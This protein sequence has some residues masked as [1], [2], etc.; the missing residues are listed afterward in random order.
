MKKFF[1]LILLLNAALVGNASAGSIPHSHITPWDHKIDSAASSFQPRVR[2][3]GCD[4][5]PSVNHLAQT[6]AGLT[7]TGSAR[8]SCHDGTKKQVH[9][10]GICFTDKSRKANGKVVIGAGKV[11][12]GKVCARMYSYFFPKDVG[13][14]PGLGHRFDW[15]DIIVWT[16]TTKGTERVLGVSYSGHGQYNK[17]NAKDVARDNK[18]ALGVYKRSGTTHGMV[19]V[20]KSNVKLSDYNGPLKVASYHV[21]AK[22]NKNIIKALAEWQLPKNIHGSNAVVNIKN[23]RFEELLKRSWTNNWTNVNGET[24]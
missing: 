20:S 6:S 16:R 22:S 13:A 24:W 14:L 7:D 19:A 5:Y 11:G 8:S 23:G 3:V 12:K 10:R 15:E 2:F 4:P 18:R 21:W 17:V 1:S 9:Y